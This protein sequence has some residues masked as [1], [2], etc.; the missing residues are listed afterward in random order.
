MVVGE[1]GGA[2]VG[3]ELRC[4]VGEGEGFGVGRGVEADVAFGESQ[5]QE[6]C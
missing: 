4:W 2:D 6:V 5:G 1:L 3:G